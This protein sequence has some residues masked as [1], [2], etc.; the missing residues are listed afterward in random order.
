S[1][2]GG[3][4]ECVHGFCREA[5]SVT[6]GSGGSGGAPPTSEI[7][8]DG[9]IEFDELCA[10]YQESV[11]TKQMR[12]EID[13]GFCDEAH[14]RE[15]VDCSVLEALR[16]SIERGHIDYDPVAAADCYAALTADP[17]PFS[18]GLIVLDI[19]G[20]MTLLNACPGVL[21]ARQDIGDACYGEE[22]CV[23]GAQCDRELACPGTCVIDDPP[24]G[25]EGDPCTTV[26]G[27]EQ[28]CVQPLVC[29]LPASSDSGEQEC[30]AAPRAGDPCESASQ[31]RCNGPE[32]ECQSLGCDLSLGECV[33]RS[34]VG[35]ACSL[36]DATGVPDCLAPAWC[37]G[38]FDGGICRPPSGAGE[39]CSLFSDCL[40]PLTCIGEVCVPAVGPGE[41]C[42]FGG[43][44]IRGDC[45]DG[46]CTQ[47]AATADACDSDSDCAIGSMCSEGACRPFSC[48]GEAC[49]ETAPCLEGRCAGGSCVPWARPGDVCDADADC[50]AGPARSD[51]VCAGGVCSRGSECW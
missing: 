25:R 29:L 1:S 14:C 42:T 35:E 23:F 5:S 31:C 37:D 20:P 7:G 27:P 32:A 36:L 12:C 44:C 41:V 33:P 45:V 43:D 26:L 16:E 39:P 9:R 11:C 38:G 48:P 18:Y 34:Q 15:A 51:L 3:E 22:E 50:T 17:C 30:G 2:L 47:L 10:M 46:V 19:A 28:D 8:D 40:A 4:L 24:K 49:S 6:G 21:Q 13:P